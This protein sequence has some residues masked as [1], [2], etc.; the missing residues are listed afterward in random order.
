MDINAVLLHQM[1]IK[2]GNATRIEAVI[3]KI[4]VLYLLCKLCLVVFL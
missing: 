2:M 3:R 4:K 1:G